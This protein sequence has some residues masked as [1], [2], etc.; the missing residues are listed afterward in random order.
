LGFIS[1]GKIGR[2]RGV[3]GEFYVKPMTDFPSRFRDLKE[4]FIT[5]EDG[6]RVKYTIKEVHI[7][8]DKPVLCLNEINSRSEVE[9]IKNHYIEITEKELITLPEDHYFIF[10]LIGLKVVSE[11][12][13]HFGTIRE[14]IENPGNDYF[15]VGYKNKVYNIPCVKEFIKSVK[16][17]TKEIVVSRIKE[18]I[19]IVF[20]NED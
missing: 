1:I 3:K 4:I 8:K 13:E 16:F 12:G 11:S 19:D 14:V 10:Q 20:E 17:D 5:D 6:T 9:L 15:I 7:S 2:A 18:F